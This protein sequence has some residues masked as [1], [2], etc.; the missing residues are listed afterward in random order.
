MKQKE[1]RKTNFKATLYKNSKT[2]I[3][4]IPNDFIEEVYLKWNDTDEMTLNIP[5]LIMKNGNVKENPLYNK[6]GFLRQEIV[7][8][9]PSVRFLISEIPEI[10]EQCFKGKNGKLI[11]YQTKKINCKSYESLCLNKLILSETISRQL[12]NDGT[13][14]DTSEG[15]LDGYFLKDNPYWKIGCCSEKAKKE[16]GTSNKVFYDKLYNDLS[17]ENLETNTILWEKDFTISPFDEN[18]CINIKINYK[19]TKIINNITELEIS[20]TDYSHSLE[21]IYTGITHIKAIY[22]KQ[23]IGTYSVCYEIT[24]LDGKI[25]KKYNQFLFANNMNLNIGEI[26]IEYTTGEISSEGVI[27][28]RAF[29]AG[30]YE[31]IDF[32][33][34]NVASAYGDLYF[35]FN[36]V[37]KILN[38]YTKEEY[39][40]N[41][42]IN[43]SYRNYVRSISKKITSDNIISDLLVTSNN[44]SIASV[45]P[46]GNEHIYDYSYFINNGLMSDELL[47]AWNKYS[48]LIEGKVDQKAQYLDEINEID[49]KLI[50]LES[51]RTALD[52]ENKWLKLRRTDYQADDSN[53][54]ADEIK[55]LSTQINSNLTKFNKLT[56]EIENL[57]KQREQLKANTLNIVNL[58]DMRTA[59]DNEGNLIFNEDLLEEL[60]KITISKTIQ[61]ETYLTPKSLYEH[62]K[63]DLKKNN[64][65]YIEF[66]VNIEGILQNIVVPEGLAWEYYIKL[67]DYVYLTECEDLI[68][69]K[70]IRIIEYKLNPKENRITNIVF[71]NKDET[72]EKYSGGSSSKSNIISS[73]K[74]YNFSFKNIW[75]E[76][77]NVNDFV[78]NIENG[79][80]TAVVNIRNKGN[81]CIYEQTEA[82]SYFIDGEDENKQLY[83]GASMICFTQDK[84][85]TSNSAL[86]SEGLNASVI[87]GTLIA[88][89]QLNIVSDNENDCVFYIGNI[90]DTIPNKD[91][92][93]F[94]LQIRN[95][96]S[97]NSGNGIEQ[98]FLGIENGVPTFRMNKPNNITNSIQTLSLNED[99]EIPILKETTENSSVP[100]LS[101]NGV[102]VDFSINDSDNLDTNEPLVMEVPIEEDVIEIRKAILKVELKNFKS[103]ES[104]ITLGNI[105]GNISFSGTTEDVEITHEHDSIV[106]S[107]KEIVTELPTD[108]KWYK[109]HNEE[110]NTD[111]YLPIINNSTEDII[112][113]DYLKTSKDIFSHNHNYSINLNN[114]TFNQDGELIK[115]VFI[116]EKPTN[117]SIYVNGILVQD[118]INEDIS[119]DILSYLELNKI[120]TI[121][122]RSQSLGKIKLRLYGK[123]FNKW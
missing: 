18:S 100:I 84:W 39:G 78:K 96:M 46:Y 28:Y 1:F 123:T 42:G 5:S 3:M 48:S 58:L 119:L 114:V 104:G 107:T 118:N 68:N 31:W 49:R 54:Y 70:S 4:D 99:E 85:L 81:R 77:K 98:I 11:K 9:N 14:L 113:E 87:Y 29:E 56:L 22:M 10:N 109:L 19:D 7:T 44:T 17:F 76:S 111:I 108:I 92:T 120:N 36:T 26:I 27:K 86:T 67:G 51:E 93:D 35:D 40:E 115:G 15:L 112:N 73:L 121:E 88:G 43:F 8:Q 25:L 6:I 30:E 37:D 38:V 101:N 2:P 79:I 55:N 45:N 117:V 57:K 105:T 69:D 16:I 75:N 60:H 21:D 74:N 41:K 61:D 66:T 89:K 13:T 90:K 72:I 71:S 83:I 23:D 103:Y 12:Y 82:G 32:L 53:L 33:R 116:G 97:A 80:D 64:S 110:K 106:Y 59:K 24:L 122:A 102:Q 47:V 95:N 20:K 63:E 91:G 62:Y 34:N 52:E 50:K 65:N 94:G